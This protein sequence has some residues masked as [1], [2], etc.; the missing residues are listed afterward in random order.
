MREKNTH[1]KNRNSLKVEYI[2]KWKF[3]DIETEK[4]FFFVY[5][6]SK[7]LNKSVLFNFLQIT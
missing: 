3:L 5:L 2:V 7:A 6:D 4:T 1:F